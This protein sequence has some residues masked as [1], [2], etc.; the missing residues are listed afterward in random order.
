[1]AELFMRA[2]L[3]NF[4]KGRNIFIMGIVFQGK[5][6]PGSYLLFHAVTHEVPSAFEGLASVFGMGTGVAPQL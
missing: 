6:N 5:K 1:M 3:S 4:E 2:F